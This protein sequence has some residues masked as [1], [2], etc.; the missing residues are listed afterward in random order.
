MQVE[1]IMAPLKDPQRWKE[2]DIPF[3]KHP[4]AII[5]IQG[6]PGTGKTA[7]ANHMARKIGKPPIHLDFAG[8][9]S[10]NFG[11]TEAKLVA[12]FQ[13]AAETE[14][15]TI[16]IEECDAL[17]W[18]RDRVND[19]N[20]GHLGI[21]NTFLTQL[22]RFI[23]RKE[24]PSLVILTTNYPSLLDPAMHRRI[25]DVIELESPTGKQAEKMWESKMPFV[26]SQS[27]TSQD[28]ERLSELRATPDQI[29]KAILKVCRRALHE[30]VNPTFEMFELPT[31]L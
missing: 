5:R 30:G 18:S 14:T 17:I 4:Y 16:I 9:A 2:W 27:F 23:A 3:A 20:M 26:M 22:D 11:E 24:I 1:E 10:A 15:Q 28:F 19:D 6:L 21:V 25:T 29:E 31:L 13:N 7:L 8:V 12:A